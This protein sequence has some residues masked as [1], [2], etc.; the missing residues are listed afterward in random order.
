MV[1]FTQRLTLAD[2]LEKS[3]IES[4]NSNCKEYRII[5][6]GMESTPLS[7]AHD[8][9]R[10]CR[11]STAKFIR[12][13]PDSVIVRTDKK[14]N[15][16]DSRNT[17]LIEFKAA[18]TGV[19]KDSFLQSV[20]RECKTGVLKPEHKEDIFNVEKD[21]LD[22]YLSL[23]QMGVKTII[24][25]YANFRP[26][27]SIFLAQYVESIVVCSHYDPNTL[28]ANTGSGTFV[29]NVNLMSFLNAK[30]LFSTAFG[31]DIKMM[32]EVESDIQSAFDKI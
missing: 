11:N 22:T 16:I 15:S 8:Y 3:F 31:L 13:I 5:K 7:G 18:A 1:G 21:A 23:N 28:G 2:R 14:D 20:R 17:T 25:A 6:Y 4:F 30:V 32:N 10:F 27:E 9:I 12:Y 19:R 26:P 24:V 29:S